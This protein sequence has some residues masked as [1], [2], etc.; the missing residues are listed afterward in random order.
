M[1]SKEFVFLAECDFYSPNLL[2]VNWSLKRRSKG[3]AYIEIPNLSN[4][5]E[6]S[7]NSRSIIIPK[8]ILI[9]GTS[10]ILLFNATNGTH[11]GYQSHKFITSSKPQ[12]FVCKVEPDFGWSLNTSFKI[13]IDSDKKSEFT[14]IIKY[15]QNDSEIWTTKCSGKKNTCNAYNES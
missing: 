5:I 9:E 6:T 11:S 2:N 10:Y 8:N 15:R 7:L 3:D 13:I 12:N 1:T 14:Y 4:L